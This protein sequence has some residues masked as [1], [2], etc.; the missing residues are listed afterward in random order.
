MTAQSQLARHHTVI[1][2]T[3]RAGTTFLVELLTLLGLDTGFNSRDLVHRKSAVAQAGLEIDVRREGAP[4]IV[5]APGF[6]DYAPQVF[7]Q[8]E[9]VID[10]IFVP[11]RELHDAA[12]SRRRVMDLHLAGMPWLRRMKVWLKRK[13]LAGGLVGTRSGDDQEQVLRDRLYSLMLATADQP[14]RVTLLR[15]PRLVNDSA[16][17]FDKLQPLLHGISFERFDRVHRQ[18]AQPDLVHRFGSER[19][20][21]L[22]RASLQALR[23]GASAEGDGD[24]LIAV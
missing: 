11:M 22:P 1:T 21:T 12:A 17:L 7:A 16:Y 6:C 20:S 13:E 15:F 9:I 3:G 18:L 4:Y 24:S 8:P 14:A 10:H 19:M 5:K 23:H 2:G